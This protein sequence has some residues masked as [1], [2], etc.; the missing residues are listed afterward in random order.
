MN[1][2]IVL[3]DDD[4]HQAHPSSIAHEPG[5]APGRNPSRPVSTTGLSPDQDPTEP[6]VNCGPSA[7]RDDT[8][9]G[10]EFSGDEPMDAPVA[11]LL[12]TWRDSALRP[13][14]IGTELAAMFEHGL[15]S[16]TDAGAESD[17][18]ASSDAATVTGAAG[19][20][21]AE[22]AEGADATAVDHSAD[23]LPMRPT[24][25]GAGARSRNF[26]AKATV[27]SAATVGLS[28][29]LAAAG[30]LGRPAQHAVTHVI[31]TVTP[32]A[33]PSTDRYAALSTD[34]EP[35]A[36]PEPPAARPELSERV[37]RVDAS[38]ETQADVIDRGSE[39]ADPEGGEARPGAFSGDLPPSPRGRSH[40]GGREDCESGRDDGVSGGGRDD[41]DS[42]DHD[43][44]DDG[45]CKA[46]NEGDDR[47]Q[48]NG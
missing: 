25:K 22:G 36:I 23:I 39:P 24:K 26:V 21:G 14:A 6:D 3:P 27:I 17:A 10:S 42:D 16:A 15:A 11:A 38:F 4:P 9:V 19:A 46:T 30:V 35:E 48:S 37:P 43:S 18:G 2:E 33:A 13:V 5:I 47:G 34:A 41:H 29:S 44:R 45:N 7:R 28:G 20:E 1:D 31:G 32:Q 40:D 12:A 8:F